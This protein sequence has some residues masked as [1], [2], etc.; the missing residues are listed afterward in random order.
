M[1]KAHVEALET[2]HASLEA[3]INA[4]ETRPHP[5][6]TLLM[7]LKKQ[8]LRIKDEMLGLTVH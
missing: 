2:K 8:K 5:D 7:R 1:D 4:E 3:Q 6:D